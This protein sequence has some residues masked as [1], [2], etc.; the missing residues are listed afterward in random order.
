MDS[1]GYFSRFTKPGNSMLGRICPYFQSFNKYIPFGKLM[2]W[3]KS[4]IFQLEKANHSNDNRKMINLSF[5]NLKISI[6]LIVR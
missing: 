5:G 3:L 2:V 4:D 1:R 6:V